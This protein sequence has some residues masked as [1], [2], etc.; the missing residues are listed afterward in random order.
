MHVSIDGV[1]TYLLVQVEQ[2]QLAQGCKQ[3]APQPQAV[4]AARSHLLS[5]HGKH[6]FTSQAWDLT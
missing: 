2:R 5:L 1:E 3:S 4:S 6:G